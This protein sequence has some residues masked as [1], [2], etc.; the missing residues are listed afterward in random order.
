MQNFSEKPY[1]YICIIYHFSTMVN[2]VEI[3]QQGLIY[4]T[5]VDAMAADDLAT[6]RTRASAAMVLTQFSRNIL[7]TEAEG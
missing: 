2:V 6:Q 3:Q 1:K 4:N 7:A 5:Q